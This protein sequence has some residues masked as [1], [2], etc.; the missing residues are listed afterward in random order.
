MLSRIDISRANAAGM[1]RA[2]SLLSRAPLVSYCELVIAFYQAVLELP[3]DDKVDLLRHLY[4]TA[5]VNADAD[6]SP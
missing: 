1:S 6:L 2:R 4:A 3:H 5:A